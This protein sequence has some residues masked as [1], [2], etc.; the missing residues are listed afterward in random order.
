MASRP[1]FTEDADRPLGSDVLAADR[2]R[3]GQDTDPLD[4]PD[5]E[6][7]PD[8]GMIDDAEGID[9]EDVLT[10]DETLLPPD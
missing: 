5:D 6:A 7:F 2:A 10:R 3:A 4:R 9:E 8:A 1:D